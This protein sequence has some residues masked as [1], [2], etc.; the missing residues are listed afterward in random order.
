MGTEGLA[1]TWELLINGAAALSPGY[2]A[3]IRSIT[4]DADVDGAA[5]LLI[6]ADAWD[7]VDQCFRLAGE[8]VLAPGN[9]ITVRLGYAGEDLVNV[10]RF[11]VVREETIYPENGTP[12]VRI[13]A[14]SAETALGE[15]TEPRSWPSPSTDSEIVRELAEA[16][17]LT[18][19]ADSLEDTPERQASRVK[20]KGTSDLV[21]LQSLAVANGYGAPLVRYDP[22][23]DADVLYF[24]PLKVDPAAELTLTYNV[25]LAGSAL[26]SGNL[27]SFNPTL[28][29]H[30]VPTAVEVTGWDAD[31]QEAIVVIMRI[32]DAGQDPTILTGADA[33]QYRKAYKIKGGSEMRARALQDGKAAS[34][35]RTE[36]LAVPHLRTVEDAVAWATRW[37]DTRNRAFLVANATTLGIPTLWPGQVHQ[38]DGVADSH[39]GLWH[40][41]GVKHAISGSGYRCDLALERV[42]VDAAQP[43]EG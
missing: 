16:A 11:R 6:E 8:N 25:H 29:L 5:E 19:T 1:P 30:G 22:D 4:V 42:L 26:G 24:R 31:K 7:P 17:G 37:I 14:Y 35:E 27:L 21:F 20:A 3:L 10:Q 32:E 23:L 13:T 2:R 33:D 12:N 43:T 9:L 40:V 28:D 34:A 41:S 38:V 39:A 18:V 36:Y 15:A